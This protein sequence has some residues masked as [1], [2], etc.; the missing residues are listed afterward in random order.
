[1]LPDKIIKRKYIICIQFKDLQ[2]TVVVA[3]NFITV[4]R[5]G[6]LNTRYKELLYVSGIKFFD[7]L[8]RIQ[9]LRKMP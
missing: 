8:I 7:R 4:K 6:I 2:N 9:V 3:I 1:M 5:L